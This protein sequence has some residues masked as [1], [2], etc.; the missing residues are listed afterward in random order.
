MLY[1]EPAE[2]VQVTSPVDRTILF[3]K[4]KLDCF[5]RNEFEKQASY[6]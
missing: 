1:F 3:R 2:V 4:P 5:C 6:R